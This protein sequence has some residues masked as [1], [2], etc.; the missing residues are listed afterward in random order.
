MYM[1]NM[2]TVGSEFDRENI[3]AAL[4][5]RSRDLSFLAD[6]DDYHFCVTPGRVNLIGEHTDYN[7]CPVLPFA[8]D[9]AIYALIIPRKDEVIRVADLNETCDPIEFVITSGVIP[10]F[11]TGNWGNY[12]K[13]A[14]NELL[15]FTSSVK[16]PHHVTQLQEDAQGFPWLKKGFSLVFYSTIPRA[17]GMSSSSALVVLHAAAS[18]LS[19]GIG[20]DTPEDRILLADICRKAEWYVGTQGGGMDQTAIIHGKEHQAV[21][22]D[23]NP[24]EVAHVPIPE[25]V[26]I[27]VAHSTVEAPKTQSAMDAYNRRAIECRLAALC[28]NEYFKNTYGLGGISFIGDITPDVLGRSPEW[29]D[30]E[31]AKV[32][33]EEPY[34]VQ[35]IAEQL[36]M[37]P[38][39]VN[40]Q[41]CIRKDGSPF[42]VPVEGFELHKRFHH[43]WTEWKRVEQSAELLKQGDMDGVGRLMNLSH[44]S[45]RD[46]HQISCTELDVLTNIARENGSLGSRLTGAGFGGCSVHLVPKMDVQTFIS[47]LSNFY[48]HDYLGLDFKEAKENIFVVN[49]SEGLHIM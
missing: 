13:A 3:H 40:K 39:Q 29:I 37:S 27:V 32:L 22:I 19:N 31:V 42:P 43:V 2:L 49:P 24:L 23:F 47:K 14:V 28:M 41:F 48:Y 34:S 12:S 26:S 46:Y 17:A 30:T 21:K 36:N 8:V 20:W 9:K 35:E 16:T 38:E 15:S 45:C 4:L 1:N 44:E 11:E 6:G 10:P 7:N 25:H 18:L 33:H 5:K